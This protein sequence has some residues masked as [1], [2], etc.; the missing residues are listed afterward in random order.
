MS[1]HGQTPLIQEATQAEDQS[2]MVKLKSIP[3]QYNHLLIYEQS[4][5]QEHYQDADL[6]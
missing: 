4:C 1:K 2:T 5:L 6:K 3:C